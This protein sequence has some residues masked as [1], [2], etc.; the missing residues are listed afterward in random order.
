MDRAAHPAVVAGPVVLVRIHLVAALHR[1]SGAW[2]GEPPSRAAVPVQA[3]Q[4]SRSLQWSSVAC[5][6]DVG[7]W[8]RRTPR[9]FSAD[10]G[11]AGDAISDSLTG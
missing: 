8:L 5:L 9:L 11:P 1:T 2:G 6:P 10:A 4:V 3:V 7:N